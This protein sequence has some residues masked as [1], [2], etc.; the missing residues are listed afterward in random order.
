M[1]PA[2]GGRGGGRR[3]LR[4]LALLVGISMIISAAVIWHRSST[5]GTG[6]AGAAVVTASSTGAGS[7]VRDLVT[8]GDAERPGASWQ[9]S[10]GETVGAWVNLAWSDP[11]EIRNL[12]LVRNPITEPGIRAGY[13]SFGDGSY[14]QFQFEANT[15]VTTVPVTPRVTDRVRLTASAVDEGAR[16]V[17]IA[18]ILVNESGFDEVV[19]DSAPGGNLASSATITVD[20]GAAADDPRALQDGTGASGSNGVGHVWRASE[21]RGSWLELRWPEPR[22]VSSVEIVGNA[23]GA[24]L[25]AATVTFGDG[26]SLP[27]GAVT[28]DPDHPTVVALM[29]RVTSTLRLTL[30]AVTGTSALQ[31]SELRVFQRGSAP[32]R[33]MSGPE[34]RNSIEPAAACGPGA[35]ARAAAVVEIRCPVSGSA[36]GKTA[37]L[38]LSVPAGFDRVSATLYPGDRA[39][40]TQP[41]AASPVDLFGRATVDLDLSMIPAGPITVAVQAGGA[42]RRERASYFQLYR[43]GDPGGEVTSGPAARGRTLAYAEEFS[44]PVSLSRTGL[45]ADYATAKPVHYGAEDFGDAVFADPKHRFDNV[46]VVEDRYLRIDVKP[47]PEGFNDPQNWGRTHLGGLLA[48]ARAGGSGF[49]AQYGYFEARMLAPATAGTWPAFWMLP[50]DNLIAPTEEV[51][52]IDAVELYGHDP[53]G[54]CHT[55]HEYVG[56]EDDGRADCAKRFSSV[57]QAL[58]W[59]TYGVSIT[60][61]RVVFFIDGAEVATAPQVQGG[62]A[63]MFFLVDLAL[64][65][66]WPVE[67][68]PVQDRASL[69]VDYIRVFV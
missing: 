65:G 64:G 57:R 49:A 12:V 10:R 66:G 68:G 18:E 34:T 63:P 45:G 61:S 51:A 32:A 55:T 43:R 20:P 24:E 38:Q 46:R 13:L 26:T 9:S 36:V 53:R 29:P 48:S 69:Y 5:A 25:A 35:A 37:R 30:D 56:G 16:D 14:T 60:P 15:R 31:L 41:I 23:K 44:R 6:V 27:V 58:A 11:R 28:S 52:E 4:I 40:E 22:E 42:G 3:W 39:A 67:L 19:V 17:T 50:S 54:T 33:R 59:H 8:S 7:T 47:L 62:Q 1:I 21:P 2:R